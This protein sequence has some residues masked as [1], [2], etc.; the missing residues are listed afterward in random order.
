MSGQLAASVLWKCIDALMESNK[1]SEAITAASVVMESFVHDIKDE[2]HGF[3]GAKTVENL[4]ESV[5][6]CCIPYAADWLVYGMLH[7]IHNDPASVLA[8]FDGGE[9]GDLTVERIKRHETYKMLDRLHDQSLGLP[10]TKHYEELLQMQKQLP[11]PQDIEGLITQNTKLRDNKVRLIRN[12]TI[13]DAAVSRDSIVRYNKEIESLRMKLQ[14]VTAKKEGIGLK[15]KQLTTSWREA[16]CFQG[17]TLK[18]MHADPDKEDVTFSTLMLAVLGRVH[19]SQEKG[20]MDKAHK[21]VV[22]N[23]LEVLL[24]VGGYTFTSLPPETFFIEEDRKSWSC[25]TVDEPARVLDL[26]LQDYMIQ[27]ASDHDDTATDEDAGEDGTEDEDGDGD[28]DGNE[29]EDGDGD[30]DGNED[31]DGDGNEDGNEDG[32]GDRDEDGN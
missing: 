6:E 26:C 28:D 25:D 23:A 13:P 31:E 32:D 29:D 5:G 27:S 14:E 9:F 30:E 8:Q 19:H 24:T 10:H 3:W 16:R 21:L 17:M 11:R 4:V 1:E 12:G 15:L 20:G 22:I 7:A 2:V 18:A